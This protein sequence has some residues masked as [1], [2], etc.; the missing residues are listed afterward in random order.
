[1]IE[2]AVATAADDEEDWLRRL[3]GDLIEVVTVVTV[4][5]CLFL[6]LAEDKPCSSGVTFS[7]VVACASLS[8][9]S[10]S[11]WLSGV[12]FFFSGPGALFIF[13]SALDLLQMSATLDADAAGLHGL[14]IC[15][16][17]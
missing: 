3:L 2:E 6:A 7:S 4:L 5:L 15:S 17:F 9:S 1:M 12:S 14:G 10:L 16:N 11:T 13:P 8:S